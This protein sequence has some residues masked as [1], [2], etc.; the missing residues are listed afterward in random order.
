MEARVKWAGDMTFVGHGETAHAVVMDAG[1]TDGGLGIGASPMEMLLMGAGGCAS[2]DVI[3]ILE[4]ARQKVSTSPGS[5]VR[6]RDGSSPPGGSSRA[7]GLTSAEISSFLIAHA[8]MVRR[9]EYVRLA[10]MGEP[11]SAI[12]FRTERTCLLW[13]VWAR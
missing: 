5:S 2:V 12:W 11:R 4:K 6:S 8:N 7:T 10:M 13:T 3:M 9:R 1:I